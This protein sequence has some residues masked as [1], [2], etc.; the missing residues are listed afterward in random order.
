MGKKYTLKKRGGTK[1]LP[2]KLITIPN[3]NKK[4]IMIMESYTKPALL[5]SFQYTNLYQTTSINATTKYTINYCLNNIYT[6]SNKP[7]IDDEVLPKAQPITPQSQSPRARYPPSPPSPPKAES[8][9]TSSQASS[10]PDYDLTNVLLYLKF[11]QLPLPFNIYDIIKKKYDINDLKCINVEK[12]NAFTIELVNPNNESEY[13]MLTYYISSIYKHGI[14]KD[15]NYED[16]IILYCCFSVLYSF[17]NSDTAPEPVFIYS[18]RA[19]SANPTSHDSDTITPF[20]TSVLNPTKPEQL[21]SLETGQLLNPPNSLIVNMINAFNKLIEPIHKKL[22][23]LFSPYNI[24]NNYINVLKQDLTLSDLNNNIGIMQLCILLYSTEYTLLQKKIL[25]IQLNKINTFKENEIILRHLFEVNQTPN[26]TGILNDGI[27]K[28]M[29]PI[30]L[31]LL[32]L[33]GKLLSPEQVKLQFPKPPPGKG[34][35]PPPVPPP[36]NEHM[37]MEKYDSFFG[38]SDYKQLLARTINDIYQ[39]GIL[40][41]E[42]KK[43]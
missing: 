32:F 22:I 1:P 18:V 33:Y 24:F 30:H 42:F 21:T 34:P 14:I 29:E 13:K 26:I 27:Q 37:F 25:S 2:L 16:L 7:F 6:I 28:F 8:P 38:T 9:R 17:T 41:S 15:K 40:E 43:P 23:Y 10:I 36:P 35:K 11:T 19:T 31:Y 5:H 12:F 4:I 20:I 3:L 39:L